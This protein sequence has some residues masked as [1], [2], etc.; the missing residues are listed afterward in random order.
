MTLPRRASRCLAEDRT[1]PLR[2][3]AAAARSVLEERQCIGRLGALPE[4]DHAHVR[5]SRGGH[6]QPGRSSVV[7]GVHADDLDAEP[8]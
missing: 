8:G 3:V 5:M 6:S 1:R 2:D 4:H 7:Y